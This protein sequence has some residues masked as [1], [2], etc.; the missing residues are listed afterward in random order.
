MQDPQTA[1]PKYTREESVGR[2]VNKTLYRNKQRSPRIPEGVQYY[3]KKYHYLVFTYE[4]VKQ[5]R[6]YQSRPFDS[7]S[8][9]GRNITICHE[10]PSKEK[11]YFCWY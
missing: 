11:M 6:N 5:P 4:I 2:S 8:N 9:N 1:K 10:K 7:N 3:N